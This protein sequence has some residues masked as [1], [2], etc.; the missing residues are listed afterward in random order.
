MRNFEANPLRVAML[1]M[2]PENAHP[3]SW[4]AIINGFSSGAMARCPAPVIYQYL[5]KQPP[6]TV[7]IPIARVTHLWT[8]DPAQAHGVAAAAM[9]P[10]IVAR[11]E[12]VLGEVEAVIIATDDGDDH[13]WRARPFVEAGL[14]IFVDKPLA[15][16]VRDLAQFQSWIEQGARIVS[17]SGLRHAPEL[18]TFRERSWHWITGTTCKSWERYGIHALEPIYTI[19]G[20]GYTLVRGRK[21]GSIFHVEAE[22]RSGTIIS[23]ACIPKGFGSAFVIHGY[24]NAVHETTALRDNYTAFRAQLVGFLEYAAGLKPAPH[25]FTE[26]VEL[27]TILITARLSAEQGGIDIDLTHL[28]LKPNLS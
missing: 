22:H 28:S 12:D 3:Y 19:T 27:M 26:T 8:D 7:G 4:S 1:G 16:N 11:P 2:I 13:I 23:L 5:S 17:S 25:P 24:A 14:P 15:T 18:A 9:I 21:N 6:G 10:H 20:P